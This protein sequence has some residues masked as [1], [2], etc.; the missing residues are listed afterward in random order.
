[1]IDATIFALATG[2]PPA[3]IAII[4][5]SGPRA[6]DSARIL[7]GRLPE[8]RRPSLASLRHPVSGELI[9]EA[10]VVRFDA[11]ATATG[12]DVVE[13]QCHGGRAVVDA[14]LA[15]LQGIDGLR[16]A[17]PGEFT[18]R[19]LAN[20]RIDLTE[21]EG[22]ADL[23]NAETELQRRSA[24]LRAGGA[25]RTKLD[26][27]RERLLSLAAQAE[28]EIDYADEDDA[29]GVG[30]LNSEL[31]RLAAEMDRMV[32]APR[33]EPLRD[34]IKVVVAGP[35]NA[36][37][38]SL[39][40]ALAGSERAIVTDVAGTTRDLIEVPLS[41]GGLPMVLVDTAGLRE[42]DD[43][44]EAIGVGLARKEVASADLLLWLGDGGEVPD[45]PQV[46]LL[47]A[48]SDLLANRPHRGF[49]VSARTGEG[50]A[51][52]AALLAKLASEMLP[53]GDEIA[54][55]QRQHSLFEQAGSALLRAAELNDPV[56]V[57]E[58]IRAARF[59]LDAVSGRAGIEDL[60]DALFSRFC[61]GK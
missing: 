30:Q 61:L 18:R 52:L 34:G 60:L 19:S 41:I 20:G 40:N 2:R 4:R 29:A 24:M 27:W 31:F 11:P 14:T 17:E 53:R 23:L 28:L 48:K 43:E 33:V 56:L 32:R 51:D 37:K 16:L 47:H 1:M 46:V 57:A 8:A 22:L 50:V 54:L 44:V 21:A 39:I 10:L 26:G 6:H 55:D 49:R 7:S 36:G 5:V 42:T 58:E 35:A 25:L 12:E 38:S 45:H 9:D 3:A 13:F 59:A 15:A